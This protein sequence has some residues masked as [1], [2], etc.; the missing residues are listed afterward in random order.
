MLVHS[1]FELLPGMYFQNYVHWNMRVLVSVIISIMTLP[2]GGLPNRT[3]LSNF[4][5]YWYFCLFDALC[6]SQQLWSCR[7]SPFN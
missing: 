5:K 7:D 3:K 2:D 1:I 6:P 4:I